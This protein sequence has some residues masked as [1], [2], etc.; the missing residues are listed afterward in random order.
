MGHMLRLLS[1]LVV[2][3]ACGCGSE[4][5]PKPTDPFTRGTTRAGSFDVAWRVPDRDRMPFNEHF[6]LEVRVEREGAPVTG[7]QVFARA[8]MPAHGHGMKTEPRTVE[9]GDGAYRVDGMLLHMTGHW[10]LSIDV[11]ADGTAH[12]A[13][14]DLQ[15]VLD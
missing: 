13:D 4:A 9:I 1:L 2:L 11:V 15:V 12:S 5:A 3:A 10:V 6:S 14:F 7:A 8:D